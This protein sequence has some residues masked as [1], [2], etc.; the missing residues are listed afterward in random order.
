M[1]VLITG[2]PGNRF[3]H[4]RGLRQGDPISPTLFLLA[5]KVFNAVFCKAEEKWVCQ[6]LQR[7]GIKHR[8]S[9]FA[10]YAAMFLRPDPAELEATRSLFDFFA[11]VSGLRY[12]FSKCA[13]API[14]CSDLICGR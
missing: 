9:L 6:S 1:R 7:W 10:D 4:G 8:F 2:S 5:M 13:I 12:N 14:V 11:D 3:W